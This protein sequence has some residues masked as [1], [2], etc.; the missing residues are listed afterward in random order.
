MIEY[1]TFL[2]FTRFI[3]NSYKSHRKKAIELLL[4]LEK[5]SITLIILLISLVRSSWTLCQATV[6]DSFIDP[7][8]AEFIRVL[9]RWRTKRSRYLSVPPLFIA[10]YSLALSARGARGVSSVICYKSFRRRKLPFAL[11]ET[12]TQASASTRHVFDD[13]SVKSKYVKF[14]ERGEIREASARGINL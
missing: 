12:Q 7:R 2:T 8:E 11:E 4:K 3:T 13:T 6:S 9:K 5:F 14:V 1:F 10:P